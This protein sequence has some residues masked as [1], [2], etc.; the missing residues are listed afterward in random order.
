MTKIYPPKYLETGIV[1]GEPTFPQGYEIVEIEADDSSY[2]QDSYQNST[3]IELHFKMDHYYDFKKYSRLEHHLDNTYGL[4]GASN[5]NRAM[6]HIVT[7]EEPTFTKHS[8][9]YYEYTLKFYNGEREKYFRRF[10]KDPQTR[11]TT[12]SLTGTEL[13]HLEC[14]IRSIVTGWNIDDVMMQVY[15]GQFT[16]TAYKYNYENSD[17]W[18]AAPFWQ[19]SEEVKT[20]SYDNT[21]CAE[22]L[23]QLSEQYGHAYN[24][25]F[26]YL[27]YFYIPNGVLNRPWV[28]QS[29]KYG[30]R[31]YSD[32]AENNTALMYGKN[33]GLKSIKATGVSDIVDILFV[34]GSEKNLI[35]DRN[36]ANHYDSDTLHMPK[37]TNGHK[38][39]L[40]YNGDSFLP[41][42]GVYRENDGHSVPSGYV[43][44]IAS[45]IGKSV[46]KL[47]TNNT[48]GRE[49]SASFPDV[50][51]SRVG[52][53]TAVT[54]DNNG[55]YSVFDSS[56][57]IDYIA[58]SEQT[59][60]IIFQDGA[61]A[62][63]DF[64][65]RIGPSTDYIFSTY[66]NP[67]NTT[68]SV[69]SEPYT[70]TKIAKSFNLNTDGSVRLKFTPYFEIS[71]R[72]EFGD[73]YSVSSAKCYLKKGNT[74]INSWNIGYHYDTMVS[75]TPGHNGSWPKG[76]IS[77]FATDNSDIDITMNLTSGSYDIV[78][79]VV[80]D[81]DQSFLNYYTLYN[82]AYIRGT[83][84]ISNDY[85]FAIVPKN[86]GEETL[87]NSTLHPAVGDHYVI[88]NCELPTSYV[89]TAE[90][91]LFKEAVKQLAE[92]QADGTTYSVEVDGKFMNNNDT[93]NRGL[94]SGLCLKIQDS[95][96]MSPARTF[97][98][99]N[100]KR[101]YNNENSPTIEISNV[102]R[103]KSRIDGFTHSIIDLGVA[104]ADNFERISANNAKLKNVKRELQSSING[105]DFNMSNLEL[106]QEDIKDTQAQMEK[107]IGNNEYQIQELWKAIK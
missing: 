76:I 95:S 8:D 47:G 35:I 80:F 5:G 12:F 49:E 13:Q 26:E 22:A 18:N 81:F 32:T 101:P 62:G 88:V 91:N 33:N 86:I 44:Y 82:R 30:F 19:A 37:A 92:Y 41:S 90:I 9:T 6:D 96:F 10:V 57:N 23:E 34:N 4:G 38:A 69:Y 64:E 2:Y 58:L 7:L 75:N 72:R 60:M 50:Y 71:P 59:L 68:T 3:F 31:L 17:T 27:S 21:T 63:I 66:N 51:P 56:N 42:T 83:A 67:N 79:E 39:I 89:T 25:N 28:D 16:G 65:L 20:I 94:S 52:T 74:T 53:V 36:N 103:K 55:I 48:Y 84:Q 99:L 77:N 15:L 85:N 29:G 1:D 100:V 43:E 105:V 98:I 73:D 24:Y 106:D 104:I 14:I 61:V 107:R 87:P 97:R 93:I 70:L 78:I 40:L 54:V 11:E 46:M 45:A 102:R